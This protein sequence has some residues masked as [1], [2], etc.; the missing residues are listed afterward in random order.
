MAMR[1]RATDF[2][3]ALAGGDDLV[4]AQDGAEGFDFS[5]PA[6]RRGWRVCGI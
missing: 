5:R 6:R 4:A 2:E 1:E 3:A